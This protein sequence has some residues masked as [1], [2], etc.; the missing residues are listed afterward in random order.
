MLTDRRERV[1]R[2]LRRPAALVLAILAA[3]AAVLVLGAASA[4]RNASA[5]A[6]PAQGLSSLAGQLLVAS[7]QMGDPRFART[8]VVMVQHDRSGAMGLVV[9]R[10]FR[11]LPIATLLERLGEDTKGVTGTI[12]VHYGGPVEPGRAFVLHT[13]DYTADGT[14]VIAGGIALTAQPEILRDIAAGAG[15]RRSLLAFG[16]AGWAPGQLEDE[17]AR[18]DWHIVPADVALVFGDG[19]DAKWERA[20]GRRRQNL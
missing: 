6:T 19:A 13:T 17:I 16:Y 12:R 1:R 5:A 4:G 2:R 10:P 20:M 3:A 18:G 15:P 9:N 8:V 14:L 7:E 11:E